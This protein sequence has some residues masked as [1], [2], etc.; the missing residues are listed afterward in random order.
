M[1][2]AQMGAV[3]ATAAAARD[4]ARGPQRKHGT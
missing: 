1:V 2:A 4:A 3:P